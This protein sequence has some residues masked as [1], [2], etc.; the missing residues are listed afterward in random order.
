MIDLP[1]R[2]FTVRCVAIQI[3]GG[4]VSWTERVVTDCAERAQAMMAY[5]GTLSPKPLAFASAVIGTEPYTAPA[6]T[7]EPSDG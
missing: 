2:V 5:H 3:D 1:L 4:A 6:E 7:K